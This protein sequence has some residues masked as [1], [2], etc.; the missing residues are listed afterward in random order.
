MAKRLTWRVSNLSNCKDTERF[1][2]EYH[3]II[4]GKK[5]IVMQTGQVMEPSYYMAIAFLIL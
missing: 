2:D 5:V 3:L 4:Q 1:F